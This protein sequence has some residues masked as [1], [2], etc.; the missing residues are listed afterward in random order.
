MS[1]PPE[2]AQKKARR[3][4]LLLLAVFAL[5]LFIAWVFTMGPLDWRPTNMVNH[6][7]LLTPP[8]QLSSYGVMD[9]TGAELT[10]D[11]VARNWFLVVLRNTA[12]TEPCQGMLQI[13]ERIKIAVGRDKHR[14]AVALLVP[15]DDAPASGGEKWLLPADG[16]L[17]DVLRHA[18][19]EPQLDTALLIVD[20]QGIAVLV[21]PPTEDGPGALKDLKRLLRASAR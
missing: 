7:V 16:K 8:L 19:D 14:I 1:A 3:T 17:V 11:V 15:D 6:G 4:L 13:A 20:H 5:P 18:T 2:P 12:C 21:Y 9:A 10:V